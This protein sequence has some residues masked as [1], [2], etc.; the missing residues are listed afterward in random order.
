[1]TRC[2]AFLRQL[3]FMLLN[4]SYRSSEVLIVVMQPNLQLFGAV[5]S[6]IPLGVQPTIMRINF[7]YLS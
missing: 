4:M 1:M 2:V 6:I 5:L 7:W 3:S